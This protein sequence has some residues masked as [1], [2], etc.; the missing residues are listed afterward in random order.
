MAR[1]S[2]TVVAESVKVDQHAR[3][4]GQL[5]DAMEQGPAQWAQAWR[6]IGRGHLSAAGRAYRGGNLCI[7][8]AVQVRAGYDVPVWGSFRE[9]QRYGRAVRKGS[10][11]T[12]VGLW[13]PVQRAEVDAEDAG[14]LKVRRGLIMR[15]FFVFNVAQTEQLEGTAQPVPRAPGLRDAEAVRS[16]PMLDEGAR[17]PEADAWIDATGAAITYGG[18]R[19][20][21]APATDG[22]YLPDFGRFV[23]APAFYGT[24]AH[25]LAHWTGHSS[26]LDRDLSGK[27]GG[28]S[29]AWEELT[30]ELA[31]AFC[32]G[33]LGIE[34]EP[35]EDHAAYLASWCKGLRAEPR[36]LWSVARA[37]E[38]AAGYLF[39][40]AEGGN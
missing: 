32:M 13:K 1:R 8:S 26:R 24:A 22:V 2:A 21:Y 30:A 39:G 14:T 3:I 18:E 40:D 7:L 36:A 38:R 15:T 12:P 28:T 29:Y 20:Y 31:A 10:K 34:A 19:A 5:V 16:G 6:S 23:D 27:W 37:A 17:I 4:V 25:E 35:R 11:G 33:R 9:W